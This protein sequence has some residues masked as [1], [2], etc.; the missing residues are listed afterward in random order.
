MRLIVAVLSCLALQASAWTSGRVG[1]RPL[2]AGRGFALRMDLGAPT[3]PAPQNVALLSAVLT[4]E[5]EFDQ[6]RTTVTSYVPTL[7]TLGAVLL[8]PTQE[9]F[10]GGSEYGILAGRT[11]SMLHPVTMLLLFATSVYSGYLGLQ[12]RRLRGLSDEIKDLQQ[13]APRLSTGLATFPLSASI[14]AL[15]EK[16]KTAV[17]PAVTATLTSDLAMLKSASA[18][19]LDTKIEELKSIRSSLQKADLKEKH[20]TTGSYLLG[21]GVTVSLLGAFN[22]YMRAGKLFPGPHLYA[23]MGCTI[24]WAVAAALVPA[25]Q[26]GNDAARSAHIALNTINVVLFAWQVVTGLDIMFKVWE[27]T[28]WP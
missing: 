26:K 6:Q 14:S 7:L 22:T 21:A 12:W 8:L 4:G 16:L 23:G 17:E 9:A 19:E 3:T 15:N 1:R 25:M 10:A 5:E 2:V 18:S 27:K 28:S 20:H 24:L 13:Q 11:A